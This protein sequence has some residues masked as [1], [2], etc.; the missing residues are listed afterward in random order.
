MRY[1]P[2]VFFPSPHFSGPR[3]VVAS[4]VILF[5][6]GPGQSFA[7]SVFQPF[8]LE[9][10]GLSR[11]FFAMIYAAGSLLSAVVA[12]VAGRAADRYGIRAT[13]VVASI[14]MALACVGM[15]VSEGTVSLGFSLAVLRSLGQGTLVLLASLLMMQWYA[16]RRGRAMSLASL[17]VHLSGVVMPFLVFS[18]IAMVGWRATYLWVALFLVVVLLVVAGFL[19]RNSPEEVGQYPDGNE[20]PHEE[21]LS[22][23][24]RRVWG[25]GRFWVLA[26]SLAS[27]PFV[28]TALVIH[29]ASIFGDRGISGEMAATML[30]VLAA[31]AAVA[32]LGTGVLTDRFGVRKVIRASLVAQIV[33]VGL[34][35]S[36]RDGGIL[37]IY[38]V[39]MGAVV[40]SSSVMNGVTWVRFYG[41]EGLGAVQGSAGSVMLTAAAIAP[42]PMG[43][44]RDLTGNHVMGLTTCL[45]PP[46]LGLLLLLRDVEKM[47]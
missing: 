36:M 37:W 44:L 12:A 18:M 39:I 5:C 33:S 24:D 43:L 34:A 7:F 38:A 27:A 23:G 40:G 15:A 30:S 29:Q 11:G 21:L 14:L 28:T 35:I 20:E 42:L 47:R 4:F 41:R 8:L 19:V 45:L 32:T 3:M 13:L 31:V 2:G 9:E 26:V 6:S 46:V 10:F 1:L 25:S 22:S 16:R 17:G